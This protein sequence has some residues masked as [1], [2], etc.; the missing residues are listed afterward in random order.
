MSSKRGFD[1]NSLVEACLSAA[2][3]PV[4]VYAQLSTCVDKV[5]IRI[6]SP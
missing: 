6:V 2:I 3:D 1:V 5:F 4:C